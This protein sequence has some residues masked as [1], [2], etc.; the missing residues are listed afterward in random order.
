MLSRWSRASPP[1]LLAAARRRL[2]TVSERELALLQQVS[3]LLRVQLPADAHGQLLQ[4]RSVLVHAPPGMALGELMQQFGDLT[5]EM[6]MAS[7]AV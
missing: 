2:S 1:S 6:R 7:V 4:D 5:G 3:T